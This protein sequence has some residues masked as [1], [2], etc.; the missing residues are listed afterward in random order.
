MEDSERTQEVARML[1]G[2]KLT[3]SSLEHARQMLA[4]SR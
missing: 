2:A 4:A 1:S 3:E